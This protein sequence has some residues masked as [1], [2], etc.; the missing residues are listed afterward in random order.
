MTES[1]EACVRG[2]SMYRRH[3]ADC[4]NPTADAISTGPSQGYPPCRGC[5]PRRAQHGHLC[6]PCHRRLELMLTDAPVVW[7]WLTGNMTA[8]EGAARAKEDHE[9]R[10]G[11][12]EGSPTPVKLDVLDL[13]DLLADRLA[14]WAGEWAEVHNVTAPV[15]L[16]GRHDIAADSEFLL[17]WLPGLERQ[18]WIGDWW[19]ELAETMRDAHALAP[20]RPTMTR[21][22]GIPCPDCEQETLVIQ[23][24]SS[25][26]FCLTC[27]TL[28]PENRY[29]IW[30]QI[31]ED[32]RLA[33]HAS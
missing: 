5:M 28:I 2:C 17:R 33:E 25:D 26:V 1:T 22:H 8:G 11:G 32:E 21:C 29:G 15:V 24:G 19:E 20:W 27:K 13:R 14:L 4:P 10:P 12:E 30:V 31:L 6:W 7:R 16:L 3:L 9:R 18:D 23:G